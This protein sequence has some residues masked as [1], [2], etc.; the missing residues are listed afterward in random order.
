MIDMKGNSVQIFL[1]SSNWRFD[2]SEDT[3]FKSPLNM[4]EK[5]LAYKDPGSQSVCVKFIAN[6]RTLR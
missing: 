3:E 6:G 5:V 4:G 1:N 2:R